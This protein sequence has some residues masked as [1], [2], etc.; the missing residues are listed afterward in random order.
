M[1]THARTHTFICVYMYSKMHTHGNQ[2]ATAH[3]ALYMY[4]DCI[5]LRETGIREKKP[6]RIFEWNE[7]CYYSRCARR[8]GYG[9]GT[10]QW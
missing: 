4:K 8:L 1:Y 6:T 10:G 7:C 5:L 9:L 2:F 3:Y